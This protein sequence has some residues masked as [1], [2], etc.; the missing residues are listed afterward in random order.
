M[1]AKSFGDTTSAHGSD[2]HLLRDS[3]TSGILVKAEV[4]DLRSK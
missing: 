1:A 2:R 4:W 3:I